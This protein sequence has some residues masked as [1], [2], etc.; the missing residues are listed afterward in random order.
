MTRLTHYALNRLFGC[1]FKTVRSCWEGGDVPGAPWFFNP[2]NVNFNKQVLITNS[3]KVIGNKKLMLAV[4][5]QC[6]KMGSKYRLSV[7]KRPR[8]AWCGAVK[9]AARTMRR[10][11]KAC[12]R[13]QCDTQKSYFNYHS[14]CHH[15]A[16]MIR[17]IWI[18]CFDAGGTQASIAPSCEWNWPKNVKIKDISNRVATCVGLWRRWVEQKRQNDNIFST[19]MRHLYWS[20]WLINVF[21][22]RWPLTRNSLYYERRESTDTCPSLTKP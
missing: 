21:Y 17:D 4:M 10:K 7:K 6:H 19:Q 18:S 22:D 3:G 20:I 11:I 14:A 15:A 8:S 5:L 9:G 12:E 13:S 2:K 1:N 16:L